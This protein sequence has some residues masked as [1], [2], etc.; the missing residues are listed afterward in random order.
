M[1][2]IRLDGPKVLERRHELGLTRDQ[3]AEQ[4]GLGRVTLWKCETDGYKH[5]CQI[6]VAKALA[7]ALG[8]R[9]EDIV[10]DHSTL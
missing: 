4:T 1:A 6:W 2:L 7:E 10:D 3:L 5:G 8:L 9:L